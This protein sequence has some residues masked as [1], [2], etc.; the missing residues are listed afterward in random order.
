MT[1]KVTGGLSLALI[2]N[3][4][5]Q[6]FEAERGSRTEAFS[7]RRLGGS[8]WRLRRRRCAMGFERQSVAESR[9]GGALL[10]RN[11]GVVLVE[12]VGGACRS[13]HGPWRGKGAL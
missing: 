3:A 1:D 11:G 7:M 6:T 10:N 8:R 12:K 5:E 13:E 2:G 4:S 9:T